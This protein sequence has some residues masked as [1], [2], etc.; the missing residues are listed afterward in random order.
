MVNWKRV[1]NGFFLVS[2]L[3][4]LLTVFYLFIRSNVTYASPEMMAH[5]GRGDGEFI[6]LVTAVVILF[7][8]GIA[9]YLVGRRQEQSRPPEREQ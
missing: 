3:G 6:Y 1:S 8:A 2:L 4:F 7:I 5:G 9:S